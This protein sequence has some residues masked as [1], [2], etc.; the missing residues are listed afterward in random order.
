MSAITSAPATN[1]TTKSGRSVTCTIVNE[2]DQVLVPTEVV[3]LE[4]FRRWADS[5]DY[6]E[7]GRI[8][9][10][11]GEVWIDR[12]KEQVFTHIAVKTE[13]TITLGALVKVNRMG[14]YLSDGLLLSNLLAD[15][16][17]KPDGTFISLEA[18]QS[19]RV[20]LVEG[21]KEGYV[22]LEGV[23]DMVL[24]VVSTSSVRKDTLILRQAYWEAGIPEYWLVDARRDPVRFNI[25]RHTAKGYAAT[26]NQGGW[27]KS[28]VFGKAFQLTQGRDALGHPEYT[29]A[30]R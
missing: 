23:P 28:K 11:K 21:T 19:G 18:L 17:V 14:R 5:D 27:L 26:R 6:P 25:L 13:Y 22:E 9:Y 29:L 2:S 12:S 3:D 30:V 24:E 4:S 8:C 16:S 7:K 1:R 10:L 15:I 20:R